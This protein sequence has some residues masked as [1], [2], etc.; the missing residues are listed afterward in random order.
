VACIAR[1]GFKIYKF[2]EGRIILRPLTLRLTSSQLLPTNIIST[3]LIPP[4]PYI[5]AMFYNNFVD[6]DFGHPFAE[7]NSFGF[8]GHPLGAASDEPWN[9]AQIV[10]EFDPMVG[11]GNWY[12]SEHDVGQ[13]LGSTVLRTQGF[14]D[15]IDVWNGPAGNRNTFDS[16]SKRRS[17]PRCPILSTALD[18][19]YG[20]DA[21][22]FWTQDSINTPDHAGP[23]MTGPSTEQLSLADPT[24]PSL[25][26]SSDSIFTPP[27][28]PAFS[29]S[30]ESSQYH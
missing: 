11:F 19:G 24:I 22:G 4:P 8:N 26:T 14:T 7:N 15:P 30:C 27:L 9:A 23:S 6:T 5:F 2:L 29:C 3:L 21:S 20:L 1:F 12:S 13:Y 18:Y 10:P 17:W 16:K 28:A 25:A